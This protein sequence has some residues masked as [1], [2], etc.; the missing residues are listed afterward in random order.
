MSDGRNKLFNGC[1]AMNRLPT[2][3]EQ[4]PI[5]MENA[6]KLIAG[7]LGNVYR[8]ILKTSCAPIYWYRGGHKDRSIRHNGTV[9]FVKTPQRLLGITAAHVLNAYFR[10][11]DDEGV[12]LQIMDAIVDDMKDR[13]VHQSENLDI[14][15]FS[16]DEALLKSVGKDI[17]PLSDWPPRPPVEGRGIMLAGYPGIERD[18]RSNEV[19]FGLFTA[20]GIARTV[21]DKQITWLIDR[22]RHV[23]D[24][25]IPLLPPEY[26]L[27]GISGGPLISWFESDQHIATYALSGIITEHPDYQNN[28]F[29]VERIVAIRADVIQDSGRITGGTSWQ[30]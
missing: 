23:A 2:P 11:A 19:T 28:E 3:P 7:N 24:D 14:A 13:R 25:R 16:V 26:G 5:S 29:S 21:T 27:G 12:R 1:N 20:L 9:T 17:V 4:H 10:D 22:E 15:T 18:E 8:N 6:R 30:N